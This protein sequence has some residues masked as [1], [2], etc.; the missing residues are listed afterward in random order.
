MIVHTIF[1]LSLTEIGNIYVLSYNNRVTGKFNSNRQRT[2]KELQIV[3]IQK[4]FI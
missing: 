2:G 4:I 1:E 3:S